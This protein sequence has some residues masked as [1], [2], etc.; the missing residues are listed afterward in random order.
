VS[1]PAPNKAPCSSP[2]PAALGSVELVTDGAC[3]TCLRYNRAILALLL[4]N[5]LITVVFGVLGTVRDDSA[6][7]PGPKPSPTAT[8]TQSPS[9]PT[10]SKPDPSSPPT[11]PT[12]TAAP[13]GPEPTGTPCNIF[14]PECSST[15][16]TTGGLEG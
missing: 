1:D 10:P 12:P 7:K 2:C 13:T 15:G 6:A 5:M 4:V 3:C 9:E 16:G 8:A 11:H 14:D